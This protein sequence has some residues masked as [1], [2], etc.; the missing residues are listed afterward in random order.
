MQI[1]ATQF[2]EWRR[3][4][5][6]WKRTRV[7]SAKITGRRQESIHAGPGLSAF[8]WVV[9]AS[10]QNATPHGFQTRRGFR[11]GAFKP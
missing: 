7:E 8:V 9:Y 11:D 10:R 6:L 4:F 1:G 2:E 5:D 3:R